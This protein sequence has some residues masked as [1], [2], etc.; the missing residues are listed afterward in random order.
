MRGI[1]TACCAVVTNDREKVIGGDLR[2]ALL[3]QERA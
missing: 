3:G 2:G 1:L